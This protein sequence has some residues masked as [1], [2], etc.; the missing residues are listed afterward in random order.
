MKPKTI[1]GKKITG[2]MFATLVVTYVNGINKGVVPNIE[3]AWS[4][5]CKNECQKALQDSLEKFDEEFKASFET[6]YPLYEDELREL[7]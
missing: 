6:R 2:R 4:Y 7:F 3:N 1:N 5:V